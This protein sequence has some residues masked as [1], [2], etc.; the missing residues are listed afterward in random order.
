MDERNIM[1]SE[2][3]AENPILYDLINMWNLKKS[4]SQKQRVEQW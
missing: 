1:L 4:N 2:I 3:N